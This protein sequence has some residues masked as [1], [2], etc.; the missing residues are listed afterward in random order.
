MFYMG[1]IWESYM[2][3]S[4]VRRHSH[5]EVA[6]MWRGYSHVEGELTCRKTF[7]CW[8]IHMWEVLRRRRNIHMW[9][10]PTCGGGIHVWMGHSYLGG[11]HT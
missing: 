10:V 3:I 9:K 5:V 11:T 4:H 2:V 6:H 1:I 8:G 7:K